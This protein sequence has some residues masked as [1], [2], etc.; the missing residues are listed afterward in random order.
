M[1]K[2]PT[3]MVRVPS[4][5]SVTTAISLRAQINPQLPSK[6]LAQSVALQV[7]GRLLGGSDFTRA[8][9]MIAPLPAQPAEPLARKQMLEESVAGGK[10]LQFTSKQVT[11]GYGLNAPLGGVNVAANQAASNT[12]T[13]G[14]QVLGTI[15]VTV[16]QP[17]DDITMSLGIPAGL[18]IT[19]A[20]LQELSRHEAIKSAS[21]THQHLVLSLKSGIKQPLSISFRAQARFVG[22]FQFP[23]STLTLTEPGNKSPTTIALPMNSASRLVIKP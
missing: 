4:K 8:D 22:R 18:L 16:H 10:S 15:N 21:V 12:V 23:A 2:P 1:I 7:E 19:P 6:E 20:Q 11:L 3:Q 14:E 13:K 17:A 5:G 9:I